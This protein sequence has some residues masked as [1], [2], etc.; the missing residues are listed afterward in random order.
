MALTIALFRQSRLPCV[1]MVSHQ[2]G[3]G[4]KHHIDMLVARLHG[5]ANVLLLESTTRGVSVSVPAVPNHAVLTI[6]SDRL[7]SLVD[8]FAGVPVT[9]AH[10]HHVLGFDLDLRA[11]LHR[12]RV[13]F[14]VTVH[15]Y[16]GIC[17]QVN[18]LPWLDGQ[19][20]GEPGV[21]VCNACIAA[22]SSHG[23]RDISYWRRTH[24][25]LY[26]EAER[27]LCPSADAR[28]R[29]LRYFPSARARLAPHEP[30]PAGT[31]TDPV[32]PLLRRGARMR[33]AV[34]GV[35]AAQKGATAVITLAEATDTDDIALH[36]VGYPE[37]ELPPLAAERIRVTGK[38]PETELPGLLARIR[39]HVVWFPA[40]WPET[41][42]YT[43]SAAIDAGL[44]IVATRIGAF[45]ERLAGRKLTWICPPD[46]TLADWQA[47]FSAVREALQSPKSD[48][49]APA[50]RP[51]AEDFY[52]EPYTTALRSSGFTARPIDLRR[53]GRV[54]V[55]VVPETFDNGAPTPC[56]FIRLL[57][58][59]DHPA[60]ADD[61]DV[62]L[63]DADSAL[64]Y[65][66]DVIA[67]QRYAIP[68][69]AAA[70]RLAA[71]CRRHGI[72]L[73]YDL[74]D[75]LT[76]IPPEH[77]EY[78]E[79]RLKAGV[80]RQMLA[81]ADVVW[82]STE[83]LRARLARLGYAP[84]LVENALDERIWSPFA[85]PAPRS[86][87]GPVRIVYM[88]TATHDADFAAVAPALERLVTER[89]G[90]V[91]FDM[92][93]VSGRAGLPDWVNRVAPTVH[94]ASSYPGFV[95]W[96]R[97][98]GGWDIGIAPLV[99]S[100]FNRCKSAIKSM[101]YAAL[102]LPVLAS[103][104]PVFRGSLADGRG[105]MLVENTPT[106]WYAALAQLAG[107]QRRRAAL[108]EGAWA[109][110]QARH[111]LASQAAAR[112]AAWHALPGAAAE[113]KTLQRR[114]AARAR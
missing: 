70:E 91:F 95:N 79:L 20:C 43:L 30:V 105:G 23:A 38:Y 65:R 1:L 27:V 35:L 11:L 54:S 61:I 80:I 52:A 98:H 96:A 88:G 6:A 4:V 37:E 36:L 99:D 86:P 84:I 76:N 57:Q 9:R 31:W 50:P 7:E 28:D 104:I 100:P 60:I 40:Q 97:Q 24:A 64:D 56:A 44:P 75:D 26:L 49:A 19:H 71:H 39:P 101:D 51:V 87:V 89:P 42:S 63:A 25:W 55:V 33:V 106:A 29:L 13:P 92:V 102:G 67:T 85:A 10:V 83:M 82:C 68:D 46:S 47:T 41:Y 21:A 5:I 108:A 112:R 58:P 3:G 90:N 72:T 8:F 93:G 17:P 2:L 94:A 111:T 73:L 45:P 78:A 114:R 81:F 48:R 32:V 53:P 107:D 22:R 12:L 59:L 16:Y 109:A 62:V 113:N 18:L 15:D 69:S 66:P 34:I 103:D 14:D 74:D 110:Y 77:P